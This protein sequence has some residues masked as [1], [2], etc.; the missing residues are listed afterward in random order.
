MRDHADAR[1]CHAQQVFHLTGGEARDG[2]DQVAAPGGLPGL[3]GE[4]RSKFRRRVFTG[5][6]EQ[7]V[8]RGDRPAGRCVH[9]LVQ[10]MKNVGVRHAAQKPAR[11]IPRQGVAKGAQKAVRAVAE[12][13]LVL[14]MRARQTK[15]D[16]ARIYSD[17]GQI[18]AQAISSVEGDVHYL[19]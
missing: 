11:G 10:G 15:K 13:E 19:S 12:K 16:F 2:N 14:R 1:C 6:N 7:I 17:A 18:P 3:F 9:A 4:A 5:N 8:K